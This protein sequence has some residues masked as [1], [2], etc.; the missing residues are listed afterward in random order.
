MAAQDCNAPRFTDFGGISGT[1][2]KQIWNRPQRGDVL[3]RLV[4][5]PIFAETNR[6][7]SENIDHLHFGK[8]CEAYSRTHVIRERK[9]SAAVRNQTTVKRD[10]G[11][12][13][14]HRVLAHAE[15]NYPGFVGA[16]F[17]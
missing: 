16:G 3:D 7:V 14:P 8:G 10:P 12:R 9:K 15:V 17:E 1:N 4:S 2:Y 11:K 5:W 13:R 6:V